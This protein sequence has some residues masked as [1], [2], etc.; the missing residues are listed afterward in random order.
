MS[1]IKINEEKLAAL[2]PKAIDLAEQHI[3]DH[4]STKRLLQMKVWWDALPHESTPKL[5]AVY[6]WTDAVTRA[7]MA[8]ERSFPDAPHAFDDVAAECVGV[9]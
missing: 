1:L 7:A 3:G 9:E 2:Q 5:A 8:G 4:F 6:G